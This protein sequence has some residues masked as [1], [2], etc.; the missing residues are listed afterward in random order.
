MI[1]AGDDEDELNRLLTQSYYSRIHNLFSSLAFDN[2]NGGA[3]TQGWKV[4]YPKDRWTADK[5]LK[6]ILVPHTHCD[7][8]WVKTYE[9]YYRT[10]T[11]HILDSFVPKLEQNRKYKFMFTEMSYFSWWWS[12]IDDSLR[13]RVTTNR[14]C[15][16][17]TN[18]LSKVTTCLANHLSKV[19]I[20][21]ANHLS[22]VTTC[23][24][25]CLC[26]VP[27]SGWSIDPFGYSSTMAYL[28]K[29]SN[30]HSMLI[31]RVHY[32][33]KKHLAKNT[34]LEFMWRQ[35]WDN[36]GSTDIYTHMMPFYSYDVPHTCGPEP[37]VCCQFDFRRLPGSP[38]RCPWHTDPKPI[39][40]LN[41]AER[42][43]TILDQWKKKAT[44]YK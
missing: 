43:R 10:Q 30:F 40:S 28:L 12:D 42:A 21:L 20:C 19:T 37:A 26:Y 17:T 39:T 14:L 27:K 34:Q 41:V 25:N 29:R 7:P 22:K 2:P 4:S 6:I 5:K 3:W 31:Q 15:K 35:H 18:P 38:Y 23:V 13:E 33:I 16:V 36:T 24:A 11:K 1:M 32:S 9:V 44:L 8:G